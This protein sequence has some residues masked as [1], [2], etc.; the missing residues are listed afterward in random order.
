MRKKLLPAVRYSRVVKIKGKAGN[1][2]GY[3]EQNKDEKLGYLIFYG[4]GRI[5]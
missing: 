5:Y 4:G 1:K 3:Y 2:R